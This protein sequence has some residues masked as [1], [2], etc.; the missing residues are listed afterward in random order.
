M[1][2]ITC[3][4]FGSHSW[5][6]TNDILINSQAL[7]RLSYA[8]IFNFVLNHLLWAFFL[9]RY[10]TPHSVPLTF[11]RVSAG[12]PLRGRTDISYAGILISLR[13]SEMPAP[14]YLPGASPPKYFRRCSA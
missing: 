4:H 1:I 6:R 12:Q 7:Y 3:S 10:A 13:Y 9:S 11:V 8:G 2:F 14:T 5:T